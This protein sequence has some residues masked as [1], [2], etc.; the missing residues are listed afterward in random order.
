FPEAA[1]RFPRT[2]PWAE[3][4]KQVMGFLLLGMAA[5]FAEPFIERLLRP[6]AFWWMLFAL[7]AVAGL[8]LVVRSMQSSKT[9]VGPAVSAFIAIA[10]VVPAFL[11]TLRLTGRHYDWE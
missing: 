1:R 2:G 3:L 5:Y 6:Q 10:L 7:V 9:R 8:F 11:L 4:V